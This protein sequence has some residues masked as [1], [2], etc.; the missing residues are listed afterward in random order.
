MTRRRAEAWLAV[1]FAAAIMLVSGAAL[2]FVFTI[3]PVHTDPAAVPS[4]AS[5]AQ[6]GRYSGALEEARRLVRSLLVEENLPGLSVAVAVDGEIVWAEGFGW[7]DVERRAPVTPLTRFR[8][9]A[10]SK[11]LTE[12]S[13]CFTTAG[14]ST[15][16]PRSRRMSPRI[17]RSSGRSPRAS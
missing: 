6:A 2:F 5:A 17:P 15:S 9:G 13:P 8:L 14:A 1:L 11:P 12:P 3:S 4:T 16:M 7:A 10:L